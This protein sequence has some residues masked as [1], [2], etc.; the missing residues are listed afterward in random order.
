MTIRK[1]AEAL[2][3]FGLTLEDF[4]RMTRQLGGLCPVCG[5]DPSSLEKGWAID[6][7]HETGRF[8]GLICAR[9]NAGIGALGDS[10]PAIG[11]A[12]NYLLD[13]Y[14]ANPGAWAAHIAVNPEDEEILG[15][16]TAEPII[17]SKVC[18]NCGA[19]LPAKHGLGRRFCDYKCRTEGMRSRES[20][21]PTCSTTFRSPDRNKIYCSIKCYRPAR[22]NRTFS[23]PPCK[24]CGNEFIAKSARQLYCSPPCFEKSRPLPLLIDCRNCATAFWARDKR[25]QYCSASCAYN[26]MKKMRRQAKTQ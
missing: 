15:P 22:R 13:F 1:R 9:C 5:Q 14:R 19:P 25:R 8:R 10:V 23:R 12:I 11:S 4:D 20:T 7:C 21:C 2:A 16:A 26:G 18:D 24:T 6:H 17:W 3:K